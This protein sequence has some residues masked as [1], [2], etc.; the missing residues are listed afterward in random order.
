M[1]A[2]QSNTAAEPPESVLTSTGDNPLQHLGPSSLVQ[3]V[4]GA[5]LVAQGL[6]IPAG[7]QVVPLGEVAGVVLLAMSIFRCPSRQL[8]RFGV[9]AIVAVGL[10]LFL[11]GSSIVNDTEWMRRAF[12]IATLMALVGAFGTGRL[13][14]KAVLQGAVAALAIN[15]PLFYLGLLPDTYGGVLTGFLGDKN[16]AGLYYAVVPLVLCATIRDKRIQ[17]GLIVF[18]AV[19]TFLTDSRTSLA[20]LALALV[21]LAVTRNRGLVFR[22]ALLVAMIYAIHYT[23]TNYSRALGYEER[24]GSDFLR[25]LIDDASW[26]KVI[27]APW[28]GHGLTE[29]YAY[30]G[31]NRWWFHNSYYALWAEGGWIFTLVVVTAY[32]MFGLRP[33]SRFERT[34]SRITVEAASIIFLTCASR[35]GEVFISL[36][37]VLVLAAGLLLT[38]DEM[39]KRRAEERQAVIERVTRLQRRQSNRLR[40]PLAVGGF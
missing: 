4:L 30:V 17:L 14:I 13:N 36:P 19:G 28:Y 37:G 8:S 27:N 23:A 22:G 25:A 1:T 3:V 35:L 9:V 40:N 20:G 5:L 34:P 29:A 11:I 32:V 6:L 39:E 38:A 15:I 16:V 7:G 26:V 31:A 2:I 24:L 18:A 10:V 21:W 33:L 12:R